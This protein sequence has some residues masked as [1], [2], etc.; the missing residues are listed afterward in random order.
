M[1]MEWMRD[2]GVKKRESA[3]TNA[4]AAK[5]GQITS[6]RTGDDGDLEKGVARPSP[7]FT[8]YVWP[9]RGGQ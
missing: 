6:Y 8:I 2:L 5:T 7:R 9:V 4:P 1:E 3:F